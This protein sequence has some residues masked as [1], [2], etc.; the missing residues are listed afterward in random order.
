MGD[1]VR[2]KLILKNV[3]LFPSEED[4]IYLQKDDYIYMNANG[5]IKVKYD[6]HY[7]ILAKGE[8]GIFRCKS[9]SITIVNINSYPISLNG[10]KY[11]CA[12]KLLSNSALI[13]FNTAPFESLICGNKLLDTCYSDIMEVMVTGNATENIK[14]YQ[15][16]KNTIDPR[17]VKV[18]RY[19]RSNYRLQLT[20]GDLAKYVGVH[21]TYLSNTFSKV[22]Q[23]SPIYFLN[24]LRI[25]EARELLKES[26]QTISEISLSVG[27]NSL[28]QFSLIFKRF[29][30]MTPSKYRE[31]FGKQ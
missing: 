8:S 30:S 16:E 5:D 2:V 29:H 28:S 6:R 24:Q 14:D 13:N 20:L 31:E 18:N 27:Y 26:N 19:I 1:R 23:V 11:Y 4:K 22:F 12:Y 3:V 25:M 17:L 21:P 9:N 7:T 10:I 15:N